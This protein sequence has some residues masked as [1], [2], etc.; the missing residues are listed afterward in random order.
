MS[1]LDLEI[2]GPEDSPNEGRVIWND[3]FTKIHDAILNIEYA[4]ATGSTIVL[5]GTNTS[6]DLAVLSGVPNYTVSV[7]DNPVFDSVSATTIS[8]GTLFSG[9]TNLSDIFVLPP[10]PSTQQLVS[11]TG[12]TTTVGVGTPPISGYNVGTIYVTTFDTANSATGVTLDVDGFGALNVEKYDYDS[13]G[14]TTIDI[15]EIQ[16]SVQYFLTYDGARFQFSEIDP[17]SGGGTYTSPGPIPV[18]LG[19]VGAGTIF[20]NTPISDVFTDLFF[21][22]LNSSFS[23]FLIAGQ[24]TTLEVGNSIAAGSKTFSWN[25][26]NSAYTINNSISIKNVTGGNVI[27]ANGISTSVNSTA[28]TISS[29][30]KTTP[31]LHRWQI[32]AQRTN[33]TYFTRNFDVNWRWRVYYGTSSQTGLTSAQITGL[34]SSQLDTTVIGDTLSYGTGNYKYLC[35]PSTFTEPSLIK[36]SSTNLAISMAD[37]AE[38]YSTGTGT[39]KYQLVSVTNQFGIVQNYKVFRSRNILGGSINFIIS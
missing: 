38:G 24:S 1:H 26:S 36:D 33:S 15:G 31:T 17:D 23:S 4:G 13:S 8:G 37:T 29:I 30:T 12:D 19:G 22:F 9:N 2:V 39:Y 10:T 11:A 21:P 35:I 34:T 28:I 6:V 3:N 7:I 32:K 5:S 20:S 25:I 14:F 16:P 27:I 18:T